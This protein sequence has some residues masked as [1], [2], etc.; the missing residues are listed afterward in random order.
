[1]GATTTLQGSDFNPRAPCGA[2]LLQVDLPLLLVGISIHAPR[3]GRDTVYFLQVWAEDVFQS[4]RPV[5]GATLVL[6]PNQACGLFQSTRPVWGATTSLP[7]GERPIIFQ[8][9]RPVWGATMESLTRLIESIFQSTRPV[10]GATFLPPFGFTG[11]QFQSTR[12][13]W[14][15]TTSAEKT[16]EG[17]EISIHAP[18]VGRD[19]I[20]LTWLC[21]RS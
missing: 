2:R 18:R 6:E 10:W 9:T 7:L 3:V 19:Q 20:L 15:A 17:T 16:T 13:V 8:S 12:P 11:M 1:M 21:L 5:W 14:G 4:T